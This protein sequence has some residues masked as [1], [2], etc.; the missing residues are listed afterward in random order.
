MKAPAT[1]RIKGFSMLEMI[2]VVAVIGT[3]AGIA[4]SYMASGVM[5]GARE[6]QASQ[7]EKVL[8][9]AVQAYLASGG[10]LSGI[11]EATQVIAKLKTKAAPE[12]KDR[13]PGFSGSFLDNSLE[14]AKQSELEA[15]T[16][17]PRLHWNAN[18]LRF[19]SARSGGPGL[20]ALSRTAVSPTS[21]RANQN[22]SVGTDPASEDRRTAFT[23]SEKSSWIW[24]YADTPSTSGVSPTHF[25]TGS[26]PN[27]GSPTAYPPPPS[28]AEPPLSTTPAPTSRTQLTPPQF[29][30]P[31]GRYPR[32][33]F[34]LRITLQDMNPAG[35]AELFYSINHGTWNAYAGTSISVAANSLLKAQALPRITATHE[36]SIVNQGEYEQ[37]N[38]FSAM[39]LPPEIHFSKAYFTG[40]SDTIS[41]RLANPNP[42]SV[43]ELRYQ[44]VP[45]P[46]GSGRETPYRSYGA[47]FQV[48]TADFP[49][50]FGIRAFAKANAR[51][52]LDSRP[53]SRFATA[54]TTLFGGHL[55]LD[56]STSIARVGSGTTGAH[57]H[58][59]LKAGGTTIDFFAISESKQIEIQ[60]AI[61][62]RS[63]PFKLIVV[64][65][66]LSPGM[67]LVIDYDQGGATRRVDMPVDRY[68]K[69]AISDLPIFSL[70]AAAGTMRLR[71]LRFSMNQD[72]IH[73]AGII[74]TNTG[75][76]V[77]NV[78]GKSGEWRNGALTLQAVAVGTGG[79][80]AFTLNDKQSNGS[81]GA[82]SSGL[83][84][85]A[86]VFWHWPGTSYQD[87]KNTYKPGSF[88]S[89]RLW[90]R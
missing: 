38:E 36:A 76:V 65:G 4:V 59:I 62:S 29:S 11:T 3:I 68:G 75:D 28:P 2:I 24:D 46:G 60:E 54:Q 9:S 70:G 19:E 77:A 43:S 67:N 51:G 50:G 69:L 83:L 23:Y 90:L 8:N 45:V 81:H 41:V 32:S 10:N 37:Y 53:A 72:V 20:V 42:G 63:Q 58:D 47:P 34:D 27:T 79:N 21:D 12:K 22:T 26:S 49:G 61:T 52:Y 15:K 74:P 44:I 7:E 88:N 87:S 39:L 5:D 16:D 18:R 80:P 73:Q 57:S 86:A 89:I 6:L 25:S 71:G 56:T 48:S 78:P 14:F 64:N 13:I 40:S 66:A 33:D 1:S 55:D 17:S 35:T 31:A 85:E 30:Q 84:W 82:A